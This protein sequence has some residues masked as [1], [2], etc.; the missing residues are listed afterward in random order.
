MRPR[1]GA[2][3]FPSSPSVDPNTALGAI[4]SIESNNTPGAIGPETAWGHAKGS[5]QLLDGTA[6]EMAGKLGLPWR[7][8]LMTATSPDAQQYQEALGKAY[9]MQGLQATGNYYDAARYYHGGPS[10]S[11]WGPKTEHYA[12]QFIAR[13][14]G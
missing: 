7:P 12:R 2:L 9:F 3:R 10:R 4:R 5:M 6:K 1:K 11:M 8:D 13:L 14:G